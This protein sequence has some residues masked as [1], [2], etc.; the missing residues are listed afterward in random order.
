MLAYIALFL[1]LCSGGLV[2]VIFSDYSFADTLPITTSAIALSLF[3]FGLLGCLEYGVYFILISVLLIYFLCLVFCI[4]NGSFTYVFSSLF[5]PQL[6]FFI[7]LLFAL[8]YL[9]Y[10]RNVYHWD[11]LSH[12]ALVV[13]SMSYYDALGTFPEAGVVFKS[14]PPIMALFQYFFIKIFQYT[15]TAG[16][17]E[18]VLY[19]SYQTFALSFVFP[20]LAACKWKNFLRSL[21]FFITACLIPL[22]FFDNCYHALYI[23][24]FLGIVGSCAWFALLTK[25]PSPL[26]DVY[27]YI[28]AAVLVLAKD[29]GLV[30]AIFL[31]T[32]YT[33][34][35]WFECASST[36]PRSIRRSI[37]SA[38]L[39]ALS[40]VV[41]KFIWSRHLSGMNV[42][43]SFSN[44]VDFRVLFDV[45]SGKDNSYRH[46][47]LL[48]Y[49]NA[50]ST[51]HL[52]IGE[53]EINLSYGALFFSL[54]IFLFAAVLVFGKKHLNNRVAGGILASTVLAQH[55]AY[56]IGLCVI[57]MFKFSEYEA[58]RLASFGRYINII[59]L[60]DLMLFVLLLGIFL[61][62]LSLK[63]ILALFITVSALSPLGTIKGLINGWEKYLSYE[64]SITHDTCSKIVLSEMS[65]EDKVYVVSQE[66]TGYDYQF[67]KYKFFPQMP[68]EQKYSLGPAFYEGDIW[69][70]DISAEQWQQNLL[71]EFDY[72]FIYQENEY[73][74]EVYGHLFEEPEK[75]RMHSLFRVNKESGLLSFVLTF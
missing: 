18:W 64:Y 19:L 23:D 41:P 16:F 57:Y 47:V 62:N 66:D 71:D 25:K 29:V 74:S 56:I 12:W 53:F 27:I 58:V 75:I 59:F 8:L 10:G 20:L 51:E 17:P 50:W 63:A 38:L 2:G 26:N 39:A 52:V 68:E 6:L 45:L 60:F 31:A 3:V 72:V 49:I 36:N 22:I 33:V 40:V 65:P 1:I 48:N 42:V 5:S 4:R 28:C 21:I 55:I 30:L 7:I 24:P 34:T 15:G 11:E 70:V 69:S 9:N 37:L 32:G 13:K 54:G 14:Y 46:D 35:R 73:F 43:R 44:V 67:F 61:S